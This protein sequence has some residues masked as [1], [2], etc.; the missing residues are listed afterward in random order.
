M[1]L[2]DYLIGF[3]ISPAIASVEDSVE[4]MENRIRED[5]MSGEEALKANNPTHGKEC[6]KPESMDNLS[7]DGY[8]EVN[9]NYKERS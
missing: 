9:K 3:F 5:F 4:E 1:G 6:E 8:N 2:W 7:S